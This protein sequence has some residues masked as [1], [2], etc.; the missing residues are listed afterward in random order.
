MHRHC[1]QKQDLLRKH[2][3][4]GGSSFLTSVRNASNFVSKVENDPN[5]L[6][7]LPSIFYQ[8]LFGRL[9]ALDKSYYNMELDTARGCLRHDILLV[10][11]RSTKLSSRNNFSSPVMPSIFGGAPGYSILGQV[12]TA[13]LAVS[14]ETMKAPPGPRSDRAHH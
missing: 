11:L 9:C 4:S 14:P 5:K 12:P 3:K 8:E 10:N 1:C 13:F 7:L 2:C 6:H